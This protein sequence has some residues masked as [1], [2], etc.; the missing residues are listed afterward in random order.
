[1]TPDAAAGA[2]IEIADALR[3]QQ[4]RVTHVVLEERVAAIDQGVAGL[5]EISELDDRVVGYRTS[6]QH[7]PDRA[8]LIELA[9]EILQVAARCR[10]FAGEAAHRVGALVIDDAMMPGPHQ[11]AH[12][13]A[14]HPA[15]A[16]HAELHCLF[17]R[18][19]PVPGWISAVR[20]S[21]RPL[22]GLLRMRKLG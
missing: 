4:V 2:D 12:D 14:A 1:K 20:P 17:S 11:P 10:A 7:D 6:R 21:R 13:V 16:D 9:H 3:V 15:E 8:R 22:R 19:S 5:K 18:L